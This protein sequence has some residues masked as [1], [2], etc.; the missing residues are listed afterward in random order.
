MA[1][2]ISAL[3]LAAVVAGCGGGD[4][5]NSETSA[6]LT[7]AE[8]IK[9]ADAICVKG[10]KALAS[11]VEEFAED[12]D[13]DT[14][15]PTEAQQE[16]VIAEVVAAGTRRQVE[17]IADLEAPSGDEEKIE[18]MVESVETGTE[19][20]EDQ[21]ELLLEEK[22]PLEE[23]SKLARDYGLTECGEE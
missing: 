7:K 13:V 14:S 6:A 22:N 8:F 18:A 2:A 9:Q 16:E 5:T 20:L 17:E 15:K 10:D 21:P 4:D 3:A 1:I 19:E 23:G 11:E 12:N